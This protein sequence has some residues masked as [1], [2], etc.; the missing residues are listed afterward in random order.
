MD[1]KGIEMSD[2][3]IVHPDHRELIGREVAEPNEVMIE[4]LIQIVAN[5]D[6]EALT[7]LVTVEYPTVVWGRATSQ[8]SKEDNL[9]IRNTLTN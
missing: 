6:T 4:R 5:H 1:G 8:F 9:W 3:R 7:M 2:G